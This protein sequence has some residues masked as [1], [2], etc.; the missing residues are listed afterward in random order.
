[1]SQEWQIVVIFFGKTIER[2]YT[3]EKDDHFYVKSFYPVQ[4]YNM[5]WRH[6]VIHKFEINPVLLDKGFETKELKWSFKMDSDEFKNLKI[7]FDSYYDSFID[8]TFLSLFLEQPSKQVLFLSFNGY[9]LEEFIDKRLWR[10]EA[11]RDLNKTPIVPIGQYESKTEGFYKKISVSLISLTFYLDW[12]L[13]DHEW[14]WEP[15]RP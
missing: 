8:E 6:N 11:P 2:S 13:F 12:W 15:N 14:P 3:G 5:P 4:K 9:M 7:F 1:M 10:N